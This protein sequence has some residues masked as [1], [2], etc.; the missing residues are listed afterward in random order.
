MTLN[1]RPHEHLHLY[2]HTGISYVYGTMG[3]VYG[4]ITGQL[5]SKV[6]LS[7]GVHIHKYVLQLIAMIYV[8]SCAF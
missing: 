6:M 4:C 7:D 8:A 2:I 1:P 5:A 3:L